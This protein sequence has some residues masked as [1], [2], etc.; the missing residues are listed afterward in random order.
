MDE[1]SLTFTKLH[2]R[3]AYLKKK[4]SKRRLGKRK[5]NKERGKRLKN[6]KS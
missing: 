5:I 6:P 2:S 3:Q 4:L 1:R